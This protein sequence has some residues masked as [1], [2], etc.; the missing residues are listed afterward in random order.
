MTQE[1]ITLFHGGQDWRVSPQFIEDYSVTTNALG[2]PQ[3]A[4]KRAHEA[5]NTIH[6]YPSS[7]ME[8]AITSLAEFLSTSSNSESIKQR[9]L[10]G[11]GASEVIDLCIRLCH[12][13]TWRPGPSTPQYLEYSRSARNYGFR[14]VP[15]HDSSA[16]LLCLVNPCNPTGFFLTLD[17][18]KKGIQH[19][20]KV[21]EGTVIIVDESMLPWIGPHWRTQ[22]LISESEWID[23]FLIQKGIK[24]FLIHSWTKLWSCTGLRLG[25]ILCPSL[26]DAQNLRKF[27]VPWS[28]N[29]IAL[30]FLHTVVSDKQY[31]EK[32]WD[33]TKKWRKEMCCKIREINPH[34]EFFGAPFLSYIWIDTKSVET[35]EKCLERCFQKGVPIR[36]GEKGYECPTFIRVAVRSPTTNTLLY[37]CLRVT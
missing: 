9:L 16:D 32:T 13:S 35:A 34:W 21:K 28:V 7:D 29:N 36:S 30:A 8:P 31:L 11:N 2:T 20:W 24:I 26:D 25:S 22:S 27:Q 12:G 14:E 19:D 17:Q 10:L 3:D 18:M 15:F 5:L 33:A 4:L 23:S 6:H 1:A 37:E